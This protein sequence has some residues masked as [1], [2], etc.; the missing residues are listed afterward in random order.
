M[1]SCTCPG[2]AF[3]VRFVLPPGLTTGPGRRR[4][5]HCKAR[6]LGR[7][8]AVPAAV[9]DTQAGSALPQLE[10]V[11]ATSYT[12]LP[13]ATVRFLEPDGPKKPWRGEI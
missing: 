2:V 8:S 4:G 11:M 13:M 1:F 9:P 3:P 7:L 12:S 10:I 6:K 5:R